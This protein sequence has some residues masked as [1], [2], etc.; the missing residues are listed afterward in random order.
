MFLWQH[1]KVFKE[2]MPV[3]STKVGPESDGLLQTHF[4]SEDSFFMQ[5]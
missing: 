3:D 1:E 2:L 4:C 5:Q